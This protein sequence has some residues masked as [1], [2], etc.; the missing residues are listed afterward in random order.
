MWHKLTRGSCKET[1]AL[2]E[3]TPSV[4]NFDIT[5]ESTDATLV[6]KDPALSEQKQPSE[7]PKEDDRGS[8]NEG[9]EEN[10]TEIDGEGN[11]VNIQIRNSVTYGQY[12]SV[13]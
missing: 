3:S 10:S 5:I 13:Y 4:Y 8:T 2:G 6:D 7:E 12:V 9:T 1:L 11:L